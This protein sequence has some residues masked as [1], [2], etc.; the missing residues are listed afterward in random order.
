MIYLKLILY[1]L[2]LTAWVWWCWCQHWWTCRS[3]SG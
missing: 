3:F 2:E 1:P